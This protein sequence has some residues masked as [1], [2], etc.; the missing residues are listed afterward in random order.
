MDGAGAAP[1]AWMTATG[2]PI[3]TWFVVLCRR[4]RQCRSWSGTWMRNRA[5]ICLRSRCAMPGTDTSVWRSQV[6]R[7][8]VITAQSKVRTAPQ[9]LEPRS[10]VNG[11]ERGVRAGMQTTPTVGMMKVRTRTTM[12]R[13]MRCDLRCLPVRPLRGVRY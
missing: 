5:G 2:C 8:H 9:P 12:I 4:C 13:M 1:F 10:L 7:V 11:D 3:L 6:Q